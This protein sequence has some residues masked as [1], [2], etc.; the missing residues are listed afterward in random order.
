MIYNYKA[1]QVGPIIYG[2]SVGYK[3]T[4]TG[5]ATVDA[6]AE[7]ENAENGLATWKAVSFNSSGSAYVT[8]Q[9]AAI[10]VAATTDCT[11]E[12][13]QGDD[14]TLLEYQQGASVTT[15]GVA[16]TSKTDP[17]TGGIVKLVGSEFVGPP[18][19]RYPM[20][21]VASGVTLPSLVSTATYTTAAALQ[22]AFPAAANSG[23]YGWVGTSS[24]YALYVS[25]G[26]A[27]G[28]ASLSAPYAVLGPANVAS[29]IS[30]SAYIAGSEPMQ[31]RYLGGPVAFDR[32]FGRPKIGQWSGT[33][34]QAYGAIEFTIDNR[35]SLGRFEISLRGDG[36]SNLARVLYRAAGAQQWIALS[37][38]P[39][40]ATLSSDGNGYFGLVSLGASGR[41]DIRIE[42]VRALLNG[43][44]MP[45]GSAIVQG[46]GQP[47][48]RLFV[49]GDSFGEPT[50]SDTISTTPGDGYGNLLGLLADLDVWPGCR[51]G[52]G[53]VAD[54]W[55]SADF[56][57]R[58]K[59]E[60]KQ[61]VRKGDVVLV[62]G[63][64]NDIGQ[65][66]SAVYAAALGLYKDI[67]STG[68]RLRVLSPFIAKGI[69][70][71]G[72]TPWHGI[73]ESVRQA[74]IDAGGKYLDLLNLGVSEAVL[75][76]ET[77]VV[78]TGVSS[79]LVV[80]DIPAVFKPGAT[81]A[82]GQWV[83]IGSG[84]VQQVARVSYIDGSAGAW[85]LECSG[86][87]VTY[88]DWPVGT[89]VQFVGVSYI[90]GSGKLGGETG[91]GSADILTGP[92]G[93][94]PTRANSINIAQLTVDLLVRSLNI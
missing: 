75:G 14:R 40:F 61:H 50:I 1:K 38:G 59:N 81:T 4:L 94:H 12:V 20:Y 21:A 57:A 30:G 5:S 90:T 82:G 15:S 58:W 55:G 67:I 39:T 2:L 36:D 93:T 73:I 79:R 25:N 43:I 68:A 23:K 56:G 60:I 85:R 92:D 13:T 27:W 11:L 78:A 35:D 72:V 33:T 69:N 63:G 70:K 53:Y 71:F 76:F 45:A 32:S 66:A 74:C 31:M 29:Q 77:S 42:G 34:S 17:V 51:G 91:D 3:I 49:I 10:R 64:I 52:T 16:V 54:P 86:E 24:P 18:V 88:A 9:N 28:A 65:S 26:S 6:T 62:A 48:T 41:Y 22:T 84:A 80:G 7:I 83:K 44:R 37:V 8:A 87:G 46:R 89:R 47:L 19:Q